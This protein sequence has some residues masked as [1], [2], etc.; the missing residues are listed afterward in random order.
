MAAG[1]RPASLGQQNLKMTF[2][3]DVMTS[4]QRDALREMARFLS[5]TGFYLAGGTALAILLG[6]RRSVDLDWFR[7][8][9]I[10]EPQLLAQEMR[11]GGI[12]LMDVRLAKGTIHG[13]VNRVSVSLFEYAYALL[14]P[15]IEWPEIPCRI[16]SLQDI[17]AMKLS[18]VVGRGARK[19]LVDVHALIQHGMT[20]AEMLRGYA[21][22]YAVEDVSN[23][24]YSL[25]YF[26]DAEKERM[27]VMLS[28][29]KWSTV[30]ADLTRCVRE[31]AL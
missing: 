22:K 8:E 24:L 13:S 28:P 25:A 11:D 31:Y 19:D 23:V 12:T 3:E 9:P 29:T 17:A 1:A 20:L 16:A 15:L 5:G 10:H 18:A 4:P 6:H 30:K 14:S 2:H 26:D 27:P 7:V 21:T